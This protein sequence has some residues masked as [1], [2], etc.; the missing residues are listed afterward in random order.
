MVGLVTATFL[1]PKCMHQQERNGRL[2]VATELL[3]SAGRGLPSL[4]MSTI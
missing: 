2:F 3:C 1:T 4:V